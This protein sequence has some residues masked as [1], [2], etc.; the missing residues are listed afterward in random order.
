LATSISVISGARWNILGGKRKVKSPPKFIQLREA[1]RIFGMTKRA[2]YKWEAAGIIK[3]VRTEHGRRWYRA[4][5]IE[6]LG[7]VMKN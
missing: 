2:L 5:E 4:D 7:K 3:S 1:L 6:K